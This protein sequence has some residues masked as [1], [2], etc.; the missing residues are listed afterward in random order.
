MPVSA[1][2]DSEL[3]SK[4]QKQFHFVSP[5]YALCA[6]LTNPID[7]AR[8]DNIDQFCTKSMGKGCYV[9]GAFPFD[10]LGTSRLYMSDKVRIKEIHN[11][12]SILNRQ[13]L[14]K[15]AKEPVT[16]NTD[17]IEF[18]RKVSS[19]LG[20]I[21][22]GLVEKVVISR[23]AQIHFKNNIDL[24]VLFESF[25]AHNQ[26]GYNYSLPLDST[27]FVGMSPELLIRKQGPK[28]ETNPMAGSIKRT[29]DE[30]QD[31]ENA[32]SLLQSAKDLRE[33]A[34]V[35]K[36]IAQILKPYCSQLDVPAS[37]SITK[38][39]TMLHL[40]THIKGTLIDPTMTSLKLASLIHPTPAVCGWPSD[41]AKRLIK[42][43]EGYDRG[44]Y[45]GFV[46]WCDDKGDGEWALSLRCADISSDRA[47]LYA[48]A[49]VVMGS[50]PQDEYIETTNKMHT[51]LSHL[52]ANI[53]TESEIYDPHNC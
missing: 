7:L 6:D 51:V 48:G 42:E 40:S 16:F 35:I 33:H 39:P 2:L 8:I 11:V 31:L 28:I 18:T 25:I 46:G 4:Y 17:I 1:A 20:Y 52:L 10:S 22:A 44:L 13:N 3:Q 21:K 49:G 27:Y 15:K 14:M 26:M 32:K 53:G 19:I 38:T 5:R 30:Q 47:I 24:R 43:I 23:K 37:P 12:N 36:S 9:Y 41:V 50:V 29:G 34:I 45:S